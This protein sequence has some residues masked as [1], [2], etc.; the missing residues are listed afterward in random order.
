[1]KKYELFQVL[2][3]D[4][5][6]KDIQLI[7]KDETLQAQVAAAHWDGRM[8]SE[9]RDDYLFLVD[10]NL[11]SF[12][13]DY[14]VKRS[15]AYTIDL[16]SDVSR[17]TLA[18]TYKHTAKTRDWFVK[19]YQTFLRAYVPEESHLTKVVGA[20][21]DPVYGAFLSKKYFGVLVQVPIDSEKT[22]TFDYTLPPNLER[23][24]YDLKIQKQPGLNDVPVTVTVIQKDGT[25]EEKSFVLNHDTIWSELK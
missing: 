12:K 19:D 3:D 5:H 25:R 22:V 16:S 17:A 15:Y 10:A 20:A 2:L 1:M 23:D 24:W 18:V 14:F 11:N 21:K 6:K 8:D 4:L 9:W 13:S 7:F